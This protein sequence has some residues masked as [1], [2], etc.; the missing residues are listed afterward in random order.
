MDLLSTNRFFARPISVACGREVTKAHKRALFLKCQQKETIEL[1]AITLHETAIMWVRKFREKENLTRKTRRVFCSFRSDLCE[2]IHKTQHSRWEVCRKLAAAWRHS[3][4]PRL[5]IVLAFQILCSV[6]WH[7]DR[8]NNSN[9]YR[10]DLLLLRAPVLSLHGS[11]RHSF[12][13]Y[14][15]WLGASRS[16]RVYF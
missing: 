2:L 15:L 6:S 16:K 12:G 7:L 9:V 1:F 10:Y 4:R 13:T 8:I 5:S 11:L 3:S 14:L